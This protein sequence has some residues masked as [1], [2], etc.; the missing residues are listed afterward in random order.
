M[1]IPRPKILT[2]VTV[3]TGG[4]AWD[5]DLSNAAQFDTNLTGTV[6]AGDYFVSGDNQSDDLLY[7]LTD[8]IQTEIDGS[9]VTADIAIAIDPVAH[10]VSMVFYGSGVVDATGDNDVRLNCAAWDADL[11]GAIGFYD[12][13]GKQRTNTDNPT[14]FGEYHHGYAWYADE[15]GQGGI[16]PVDRS[17]AFSLQGKSISGKVKTQ[18]FGETFASELRLQYLERHQARQTSIVGII[19]VSSSVDYEEWR[20]KVFSDGVGYG[21]AP[22][23]PYNRNEPLECWWEEARKGVE[24]RV[25]RDGYIVTSRAAST[26]VSTAAAATTITDAGKSWGIEPYEWSGRIVHVPE[27]AVCTRGSN[28]YTPQNFYIASHTATV[29]TVANAHPSGQDADGGTGGAAGETY[30]IFDHPYQTYVVDLG[31]MSEFAPREHPAIDRY[32]ITIPLLRYV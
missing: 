28:S 7:A 24:F 18:F 14:F 16:D 17:A 1:S 29:L 31:E 27:F 10:V 11:C 21:S 20:T 13:L 30:Y 5:L 8:S 19:G 15:D 23:A 25:Y 12:S 26:G 6:P 4:W 32:D 22:A 2:R 9:A 3:P